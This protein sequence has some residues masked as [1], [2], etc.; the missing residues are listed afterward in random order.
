MSQI[1]CGGYSE[2]F[3]P[4]TDPATGSDIGVDPDAPQLQLFESKLAPQQENRWVVGATWGQLDPQAEPA[5]AGGAI[6]W[7]DDNLQYQSETW[8][9][10]TLS[11]DPRDSADKES[12]GARRPRWVGHGCLIG[13]AVFPNETNVTLSDPSLATLSVDL[14]PG[15]VVVPGA[16][17]GIARYDLS[18]PRN[19]QAFPPA[20]ESIPGLRQV[21]TN[22]GLTY[23]GGAENV[24]FDPIEY[25]QQFGD[26]IIVFE[27]F[28]AGQTVAQVQANTSRPSADSPTSPPQV[29]DA[30]AISVSYSFFYQ[31]PLAA[32]TYDEEGD[33]YFVGA[34]PEG[35]WER[36][37]YTVPPTGEKLIENPAIAPTQNYGLTVT[38]IE[39]DTIT[40][41]GSI[42]Q[43][44]WH[45]GAPTLLTGTWSFTRETTKT[46]DAAKPPGSTG[47]AHS[48][49][50]SPGGAGFAGWPSGADGATADG[51]FWSTVTI[52]EPSY[53][54]WE[55][56]D[57]TELI[58]WGFPGTAQYWQE[59]IAWVG[60]KS[61]SVPQNTRSAT[62]DTRAGFAPLY[63]REDF[64]EQLPHDFD[65]PDPQVPLF[66]GVSY[67]SV[68]SGSCNFASLGEFSSQPGPN[69]GWSQ[70]PTNGSCTL[71]GQWNRFPAS[72]PTVTSQRLVNTRAPESA[73]PNPADF[74]DLPGSGIPGG[75]APGSDPPNFGY[76]PGLFPDTDWTH[77]IREIT[78]YEIQ[79]AVGPTLRSRRYFR[80]ETVDSSAHTADWNGSRSNS[81]ITSGASTTT[82]TLEYETPYGMLMRSPVNAASATPEEV[83]YMVREL[84][85]TTQ[86]TAF[87]TPYP[88]DTQRVFYQKSGETPVEITGNIEALWPAIAWADPEQYIWDRNFSLQDGVLYR[89]PAIA[90]ATDFRESNQ[91]LSVE[92]YQV[93]DGSLTMLQDRRV[94]VRSLDNSGAIVFDLSA[95]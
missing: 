30:L 71:Y 24:P 15:T 17:A 32:Y 36:W 74:P 7:I 16:I 11:E 21:T 64:D 93:D 89:Y 86:S 91:T 67:I 18:L 95:G 44:L 94:K 49:S 37:I 88:Y 28:H 62:Y 61:V 5:I 68:G 77:E 46:G 52:T 87:A 39:G 25:G 33:L 8:D 31:S 60:L 35:T 41:T 42:H 79:S 84:S 20:A 90:P 53:F 47:P 73:P 76:T 48:D 51:G 12:W 75:G 6:A 58:E 83:L 14:P 70:G 40:R 56:E 43:L 63:V 29:G 26:G 50:D 45:Y 65:A 85:P 1:L 57:R 38:G 23:Y 72:N 55:A 69:G 82:F 78:E 66:N 92:A 19:P 81:S 27:V 80:L 10:S 34:R 4:F 59:A 13:D 22:F 2:P 54:Y 9:G 3:A